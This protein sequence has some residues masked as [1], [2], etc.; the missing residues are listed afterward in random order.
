MAPQFFAY[1]LAILFLISYR[2]LFIGF[3]DGSDGKETVCYAGDLDSIL[4]G[5]WEDTLEEEMAAYS[6]IL[7]TLLDRGVRGGLHMVYKIAKSQ[8][9]LS[10]WHYW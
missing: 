3:S 8:T 4:P 1:K 6:S 7:A 2:C 10:D 9:R 5:G